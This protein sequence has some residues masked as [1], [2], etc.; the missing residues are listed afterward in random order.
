MLERLL[1]SLLKR[2]KA[3][4]YIIVKYANEL[5][6]NGKAPKTMAV[7]PDTHSA[8]KCGITKKHFDSIE[9]AKV[10]LH[11]LQ[12]FN[13]AVSYGIC[14]IMTFLDRILGKF[15]PREKYVL[16]YNNLY[17]CGLN[18]AGGVSGDIYKAEIYHS[19]EE[20]DKKLETLVYYVKEGHPSHDKGFP[21]QFAVKKI[22]MLIL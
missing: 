19:K 3:P 6:P 21:K 2:N 18:G 17:Y 1:L 7:H 9:E 13:P 5:Y 10:A 11:K 4:K 15:A 12:E 14:K 22:E 20:A 8:E 16:H